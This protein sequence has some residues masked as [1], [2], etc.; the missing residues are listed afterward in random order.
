MKSFKYSLLLGATSVLMCNSV[1][2]A[3][4][5]VVALPVDSKVVAA[6]AGKKAKGSKK[7]KAPVA[8]AQ[9]VE[10]PVQPMMVPAPQ[11]VA[12]PEAQ[13]MMVQAP[14][15]VMVDPNAAVAAPQMMIAAPEAQPMMVPADA[16]VL[17]PVVPEKA[18]N[19]DVAPTA[20]AESNAIAAINQVLA[21]APAIVAEVPA[22]VAPEVA[23]EVVDVPV[24]EV[25][26]P[27]E[28]A[29]VA[30]ASGKK[31]KGSKKVKLTPEQIQ[32][33]KDA[34]AGKTAARKAAKE[35][36]V[37]VVEPSQVVEELQPAAEEVLAPAPAESAAVNEPASEPAIVGEALAA[38]VALAPAPAEIEAVNEAAH[39]VATAPA[40]EGAAPVAAVEDPKPTYAVI[41]MKLV[42]G[43]P[44]I[45]LSDTQNNEFNKAAVAAAVAAAAANGEKYAAAK[46]VVSPKLTD[47]VAPVAEHHDVAPVAEHH[48]AVAPVAEHHDAVAPV[49]E[50]HDVALAAEHAVA[51]VEALIVQGT[52]DGSKVDLAHAEDNVVSVAA[53]AAPAHEAAAPA[54]E[55]A[56]PAH[57][58]A[59]PAHEA[60]APAH[61]AAAP[62][63]EAVAPAPAK[64]EK[65]KLSEE[66]I[67]KRKA[68]GADKTAERKAKKEKVA[69]DKPVAEVHE[70]VPPVQAAG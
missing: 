46:I 21:N 59:A 24:A 34:G 30:V 39:E 47:A 65:V 15:Q 51:P 25:V 63:H 62:A 9:A 18:M 20:S 45:S 37:A 42:D 22:E 3:E 8:V 58:A 2:F 17:A 49:A 67:A 6:P 56:A 7:T 61:E 44:T 16:V 5:P 57:E 53:P 4:E 14:A 54:H 13:P 32:A 68:A 64:K 31:A 40:V 23:P 27:V 38:E 19:V 12:A 10:V 69:E 43:K 26:A 11:M 60:A 55:A 41:V 36:A 50:H 52:P 29:P 1:L 48:D 33:L 66:E 28:V 70:A 35:Q